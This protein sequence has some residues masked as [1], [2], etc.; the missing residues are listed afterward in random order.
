M[1]QP[2]S[3][4]TEGV[5]AL[6]QYVMSHGSR[7]DSD[8]KP[9]RANPVLAWPTGTGKSLVP[10]LFV[11][12]CAQIK[13]HVRVMVL[14]PSK[15]LV[16]QNIAKMREVVPWMASGIHC[17]GLG[18]KDVMQQ[19]IFGTPGSVIRNINKFGYFDFL[20]IDEA[21][22]V[23]ADDEARFSQI[24]AGLQLSNPFLYVIGLS[25]TPFRPKMGRLIYGP[26][27][28]DVVHDL[29]SLEQFNQLVREGYLA[30]LVPRPTNVRLD[31]STVGT[32]AG[33]F[34]QGQLQNAVDKEEITQAALEEAVQY[35]EHCRSWVVFASGNEHAEHVTAALNKLGI[36]ATFV[37]SGVPAKDRATRL[38][39]F[40]TGKYQAIVN[41]N[42]LTT[43]FDHAAID[44]IIMLR[45]T[46]SVS[47][48]VQMLGRGTRPVYAAGYP[49]GTS[50]QRLTAIAAGSK[51]NGCLVLDYAGNTERLGPIND[52]NIP[53]PN[54]GIK[55]GQLPVKICVKN[56]WGDGCGCYNHP[57]VTYCEICAQPFEFEVKIE[58]EASDQELIKET[59]NKVIEEF[60]VKKIFYLPHMK[61]GG[62]PTL[63][64]EYYCGKG[65]T[66]REW[67]PIGKTGQPGRWAADWWR[68]RAGAEKSVPASVQEAIQRSAELKQPTA[69]K[70]WTAKTPYPEITGYVF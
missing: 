38:R 49:V 37:H 70:V 23:S 47:L 58:A 24:I 55:K 69:I 28:T 22:L 36:A 20:F 1:M 27:F 30:R 33:E 42:I 19:I 3:Y 32:T 29:T 54:R 67:L 41:N 45:P 57:R 31:T 40:K 2:R 46:K 21:H 52:P 44:L 16:E 64:V 50:E 25:A 13:P 43:G 53:E 26:I 9:V 12:R 65:K 35:G 39:M 60:Y 68:K 66:F 7:L 56:R 34:N 48:W 11:Q 62:E 8:G 15:E 63:K 14:A 61:L 59:A 5:E 17:A 18:R 10:P 51:P 6:L 4:Q